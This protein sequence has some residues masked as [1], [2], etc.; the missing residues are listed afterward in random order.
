[1]SARDEFFAGLADGL[2]GS[3]AEAE[4]LLETAPPS[5]DAAVLRA[6]L[7]ALLAADASGVEEDFPQFAQVL[8]EYAAA[9]V[10]ALREEIAD[11]IHRAE[12]PVFAVNER[13]DLVAK[14]VRAVDVRL[15]SM[16]Y[17]AP[18][19]VAKGGQS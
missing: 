13:P 12:L 19:W 4:R 1:M 8:D 6:A 15:V 3:T 9:E 16:G 5:S 10:A 18:Y 7:F 2:G 17:A 14:T 11:D